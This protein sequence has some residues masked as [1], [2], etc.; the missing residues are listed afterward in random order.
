M[1][2]RPTGLAG[3]RLIE[4]E[5][6][7][8]ERGFFARTFCVQEFA[9]QGLETGFV[10]HSISHTER[11]GSVRGMHFQKKPH[12]EVKLLRCIRG[13]IHDVLIDLRPDSPT[14]RRWEAY[15]LTAENRRQLYVP[16]GLA[17]GF[18]TLL[19]DTEVA[20]LISA[21]YA[22]AAAA[23]IRHDDPA[24]AIA[25]PLPVADISPKDRAWPDWGCQTRVV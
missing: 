9:A 5:P 23:G 8:D 2:F 17:H 15:E 1:R 10:Q 22:P 12:E 25:W 18:Q 20:Y 3:V 16:A 7:S 11:A 24:F 13:A 21:F 4:L 19:P 14:Y 6:A